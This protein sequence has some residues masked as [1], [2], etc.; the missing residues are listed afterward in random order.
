M[1]VKTRAILSDFDNNGLGKRQS[2]SDL[3]AVIEKGCQISIEK[4]EYEGVNASTALLTEGRTSRVF[5]HSIFDHPHTACSCF[6]GVAFY[7]KEVDGI[8]LVD[9]AFKGTTP[10]GYN[11][12]DVANAAAGKQ[13]SGYA[14]FAINYLRSRK[15]LQADGGGQRIVW[16]PRGLKEKFAPDKAWIATEADVQNLEELTEF[17]KAKFLHT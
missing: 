15:F 12:D 2:G 6:Q 9:R 10:N 8:G 3:Q 11:W 7:I 16:M 17:V 5:L 13:S 14:P 1:E 4:G